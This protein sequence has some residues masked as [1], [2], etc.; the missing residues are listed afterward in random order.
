MYF[1]LIFVK[2]CQKIHVLVPADHSSFPYISQCHHSLTQ[3]VSLRKRKSYNNRAHLLSL[4]APELQK[5]VD[6]SPL[7]K[8]GKFFSKVVLRVPCRTNIFWCIWKHSSKWGCEVWGSFDHLSAFSFS[9]SSEQRFTDIWST[10]YICLTQIPSK[11]LSRILR[12]LSLSC[13]DVMLAT[14]S[15][16]HSTAVSSKCA[17]FGACSLSH[18][19][20]KNRSSQCLFCLQEFWIW[21]KRCVICP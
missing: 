8:H 21:N 5:K 15:A 19:T 3:K 16:P 18:N 11:C 17:D 14:F 12:T 13:C 6:R 9:L 20:R 4:P 10:F 2:T 7:P 1:S